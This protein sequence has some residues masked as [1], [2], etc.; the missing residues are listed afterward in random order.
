VRSGTIETSY[1]LT[2]VIDSVGGLW[3][4]WRE[5]DC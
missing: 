5:I 1:D 3:S 2:S 4:V